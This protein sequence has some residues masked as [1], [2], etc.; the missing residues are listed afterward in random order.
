MKSYKYDVAL[1]YASE[2][3]KVVKRVW[4]ILREENVCTFY[5][6]DCQPNLVGQDKET[7]FYRVFKKESL[8]VVTFVS[9][10]YVIKE[11]PM[12]EANVA[13]SRN[14]NSLIP[15]YLDA[16]VSLPGLDKDIN[17]YVET[18][19]AKIADLIIKKIHRYR[20][21]TSEKIDNVRPTLTFSNSANKVIVKFSKQVFSTS[22]NTGSLDAS[23]FSVTADRGNPTFSISHSG[24]IVTIIISY[25]GLS[26]G[27][28]ACTAILLKANSA[29]DE[30]GNVCS[31]KSYN[32]TY[33]TP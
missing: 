13:M 31:Q 23:D 29:Y 7:F 27:D 2:D 24:D 14:D 12:F 5:A 28:K 25:T 32:F 1:S 22:N 26:T 10:K 19:E 3:E 9:D 18:N 6:P 8:F 20:E 17:Y 15:I 4:K 30:F 16:D 21:T 11:D 33:I